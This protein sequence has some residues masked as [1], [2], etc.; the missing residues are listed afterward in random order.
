MTSIICCTSTSEMAAAVR[1][2]NVCVKLKTTLPADLKEVD[3]DNMLMHLH[4]CGL[5][6]LSYQLKRTAKLLTQSQL[7]LW[8]QGAL[9][10]VKQPKSIGFMVPLSITL[11]WEGVDA[12]K[13]KNLVCL[14]GL[15]SFSFTDSHST[16]LK[17]C[18]TFPLV[19]LV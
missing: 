11:D 1:E 17:C 4:H 18:S 3:V 14:V 7:T 19:Y 16:L 12:A 9:I 6:V 10:S 2:L 5:R 15:Y 13:Y 8:T